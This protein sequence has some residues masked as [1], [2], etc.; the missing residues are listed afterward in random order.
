[1]NTA[2]LN[3]RDGDW[4]DSRRYWWL[5]SILTMLLPVG[6]V[7]MVLLT[8][9]PVMWWFG[10]LFVFGVI[11]LFDVLLGEETANPP[12]E[13][14]PEL[15]RDRY[16]RWA[17]YVSVPL[18]YAGFLYAAWVAATW[19]LAWY[20]YL[21]LAVSTGCATGIAINTAHELGH[22]PDR[23]EKWLAKVAL[24]PV[25]YGHFYVEHN[26]GH[27]VRVSTP[28]D[29]ASSRFGETFWAFLPRTVIGS[30]RSAWHLEKQRLS[31]RRHNESGGGGKSGVLECIKTTVVLIGS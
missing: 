2:T 13:S 27:H 3:N 14:V 15:E 21:G 24:A 29:P 4:R 28:E 30:L 12:E 9:W 16:Y 20:S 6:A 5:L 17:V 23:V 8:G 10:F 18:L 31:Q 7:Q 11:P 19:G 26:R 25:F 22:K 1:M